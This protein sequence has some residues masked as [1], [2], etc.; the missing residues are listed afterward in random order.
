[1]S[2]FGGIKQAL[3]IAR[4]A[5]AWRP[6]RLQLLTAGFFHRNRNADAGFTDS[7]HLQAASRWIE[8][9]QDAS[10]DGGICGR[11]YLRRGWS[12]SYPE[13]TGYLIPTLLR[14]ADELGEPRY[15]DR[16]GRA[17]DF[18]LSVQLESGAFPALEIAENRTGPSIFNSAQIVCGLRAWH[19]AT[20]DERAMKAMR[21]ACDWI[22]GEQDQDGAWRKHLYGNITYTYMAHAA[23]WIAEA[24]EYLRYRPYLDSARRHLEWVLTHRD[25]ETGWFN[26][27]GFDAEEHLRRQAP[28]HTI[29]Y[30]IWGVL[31]I[32]RILAHQEGMSA[33]RAAAL[34]VAR[35]LELSGCLPGILDH[36]WRPKA[37]HACL[38]GNAQMALIWLELHRLENDPPL[39]SA[40]CKAID[41]VKRA[42]PMRA[43][44][45]NVRGGI[46][47]SDPVWGSYIPLALPN[48]AAKFFVDALI[49][50]RSALRRL[51]VP[52][53]AAAVLP[54]GSPP[55]PG[56]PAAPL[57]KAA[58]IRTVLYAPPQTYKVLDF[59]E[60]WSQWGYRPDAVVIFREP[61]Q[62]FLPRL[63][64]RTRDEGFL[65][66]LRRR[67]FSALETGSPSDVL[68]REWPPRQE[69]ADYCREKGIPF[70]ET[71]PVA[72][73]ESLEVVRSL[74]PDLAIHAGVGILRPAILEIPRL[75]TI[76]AHMGILPS[77]RGMNVAEWSR[78]KG[79]P[80]GCT[81]HL[82][83]PG[84]DTGDIIGCC[85]VPTDRARS[86]A[87]L[88]D[89]VDQAQIASLGV[90]VRY[91]V[92]TGRLPPL[93]FQRAE[94]GR[95]LFT[96][97]ADVRAIL[98]RTLHEQGLIKADH[99]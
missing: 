84:I 20:G 55:M 21:Q 40:A 71:G 62:G 95:Q 66:P 80:V 67:F 92:E 51:R 58:V 44:D 28:T 32:S 68:E 38:T 24:G 79:D 8:R 60:A 43:S 65:T 96:M 63:R 26:D 4:D 6:S 11:Y 10:G 54:A 31:L 76:N 9:A 7:D 23:C 91:A 35:R 52:A 36:R 85:P 94:A 18:L 30:T 53:A 45:G 16:A 1:M 57:E 15:R 89:K 13:T 82:V 12:S 93:H 83:D 27:C 34:S 64:E 97:H 19:A 78:L 81:V 69:V 74:K 22:V 72:A 42:Q 41:L 99:S 56:P 46:A 5:R 75:G 90:V 33:A 17:V 70:V 49:E 61:N 98:D 37:S 39:L 25:A 73:A 3:R 88:R 86:I 29:A 77:Y 14:L 87:E 2:H 50:K 59:I 48:W 47:G